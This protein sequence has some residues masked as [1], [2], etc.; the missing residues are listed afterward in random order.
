MVIEVV[1]ATI[2]DVKTKE[3]KDINCYILPDN[4][5]AIE[6]NNIINQLDS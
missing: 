6:L 4:I 2:T 5:T 3:E 1:K